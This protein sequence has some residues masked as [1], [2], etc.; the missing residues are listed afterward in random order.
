MRLAIPAA[1]LAAA[2][3]A[4]GP[5]YQP[6]PLQAPAAWTSPADAGAADLSRW[7]T[8]F[9][10]PILDRLVERA[11]AANLDL[12]VATA[13]VREAR[14]VV[15]VAQGRLL[16]EVAAGG[17]YGRTRLSENALQFPIDPLTTSRY[18]AGFD[19]AWEIDLFG[20]VRR[21]REAA[22]AEAGAAEAL[23]RA[24]LVTLLGDVGLNY[25]GVRGQQRLLRALRSN[26]ESAASTVELTRARLQAGVATALDLARA[27]AQRAA[28]EAAIPPAEAQLRRLIHRLGV[29]L[30][31]PP[32]ALAAELSEERP[33]P[34]APDRVV[35]GLPSDLLLRRPDVL[36]A[37]RRLAAQTA[38]IGV[39]T[40]ELFPR[41]S[42][43]G[44]FGWESLSSGDLF[45]AASRTWS[46]GP[47]IRWPIFAAGR[48]RAQVRVE[49]ARQEAA[50]AEFEHAVLRA[51]EDVEN[52]LV[53]YAQEGARRT[54]LEAAVEAN[55]RAVALADD[56]QRQGLAGFLDVL[57][58]RRS[59]YVAE[60]ELARS[61]ADVVLALVALY[62]ALGGG[63]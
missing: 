39:A 21:E 48:L 9:R 58:A 24:A 20:G 49:E 6:P 36:A 50:L 51:L 33:I 57:D 59:M 14:A 11:V 13:R 54:Q 61:E 3:C 41:V 37:E 10:D 5:D 29:L 45:Q 26:V 27:E 56:L 25:V 19:A 60:A 8:V 35:V 42:L 12:R 2:G 55:R 18:A 32:G 1:L 31:G 40:A 30:G 23:R 63:W 4:V 46:V 34:R 16:P 38:R 43:T 7:W 15:G 52:G 53:A 17:S 62:K 22:V 47:S 44:A 28:A